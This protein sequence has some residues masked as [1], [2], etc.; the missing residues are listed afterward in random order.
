[1]NY[2]NEAPYISVNTKC[3]YDGVPVG[4]EDYRLEL[5]DQPLSFKQFWVLKTLR[6]NLVPVLCPNPKCPGKVFL[7]NKKTKQTIPLVD[8]A[9]TKLA[10]LLIKNRDKVETQEYSV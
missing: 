10:N 9:E 7:F 6:D 3:P 4:V 5:W 2:L 1:M 8:T